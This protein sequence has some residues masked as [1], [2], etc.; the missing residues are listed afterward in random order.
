MAK[1][2][3]TGLTIEGRKQ[4]LPIGQEPWGIHGPIQTRW[5]NF[6]V[7]WVLPLGAILITL[8]A[9]G[10]CDVFDDNVVRT[11]PVPGSALS[12]S[13]PAPTQQ[14]QGMTTATVKEALAETETILSAADRI[15]KQMRPPEEKAVVVRDP[16]PKQ[17]EQPATPKSIWDLPANR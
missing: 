15:A 4:P 10:A 16:A 12:Q 2:Q 6:H 17:Q 13:Q 14:E 9:M 7:Y 3:V 8:L 11:T 5:V 1:T